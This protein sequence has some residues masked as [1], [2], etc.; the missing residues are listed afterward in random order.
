MILEL[1]QFEEFPA[2]IDLIDTKIRENVE[3]VGINSIDKTMLGLDIQNSGDDYFCQGQLE[4]EVSVGCARCLEPFKQKVTNETDFIIS[5]FKPGDKTASDD[6]DR[7][8]FDNE[9]RAD[10]WEIVRQ[11]V[12]L[13]LAMK[14]LCRVDCQGLC[15]HCGTNLNEETCNCKINVVDSRM[16][17]LKK[18]L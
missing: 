13:A 17:S 8:Y 15:P 14:P 3:I 5:P 1:K 18:L 2:H 11:T 6:E 16:E 9:L 12:I 10:L 7:V 4:A